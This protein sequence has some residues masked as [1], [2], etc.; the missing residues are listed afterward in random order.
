MPVP[1]SRNKLLPVRGNAAT[2]AANVG[3][4]TEGEICYALD[5]DRYYHVEGGALVASSVP[6]APTDSQDYVRNN[7]AWVVATGGGGATTL[8]GLTDVNVTT[9]ASGDVLVY[10]GVDSFDN[11]PLSIDQLSEVDTTNLAGAAGQVLEWSGSAWQRGVINQPAQAVDTTTTAPSNKENLKYDGTGW[12]NQ[13]EPA[14]G[15]AF[16]AVEYTYSAAVTAG[17]VGSGDWAVNNVDKTIATTFYLSDTDLDGN[18]RTTNAIPDLWELG[19]RIVLT[20]QDN[21]GSY[22]IYDIDG[23]PAY[24]AGD[25]TWNTSISYVTASA[26]FNP[27]AGT[28]FV[29]S[30]QIRAGGVVLEGPNTFTGPNRNTPVAVV[31]SAGNATI[32]LSL[33]NNFSCDMGSNTTFAVSNAVAGQHGTMVITHT[34]DAVV[35]SFDAA[36]KFPGGTFSAGNLTNDI[37]VISFYVAVGGGTPVITAN[38]QAQYS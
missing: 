30:I 29:L 11:G 4:L 33:S 32:D 1:A 28:V 8:D 25:G 6:E 10:D 18:V 5:E 20:E 15:G 14:A 2:L 16:A 9:P 19:S 21:P 27:S 34:A 7:G 23:T 35:P 13:K 12:K 3:S 37:D 31:P 17:T 26:G 22:I 24:S 38:Y 36:F